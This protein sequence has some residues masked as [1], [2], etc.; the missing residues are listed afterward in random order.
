MKPKYLLTLLLW[1][2]GIFCMQAQQI[3]ISG[4]VFDNNKE[5][6][7]GAT[8]IVQGTTH[9]ITTDFDGKFVISVLPSQK[10]EVSFLG[11]KTQV[12]SVGNKRQFQIVLEPELLE[13]EEV[14]IVGYGTQRK[15]DISTAVSSVKMG[16]M[17]QSGSTQTL[18]ALQGKISGVQITS[19]DG[20]LSS[21]V[22]FKIRGVNSITG[23]TQ[24]LF[25]I[26]GVPMPTQ[27]ITNSDTEIVNNP[28]L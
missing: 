19:N 26:D 3:S 8:I 9:G 11:Y 6:L 4:K 5:P 24:P 7:A 22:T 17:A 10:I 28:L 23:G 21:G 2:F 16:E 15:S 25:V 14:V 20:S 27:R 12:L 1:V 13:M 18:Q